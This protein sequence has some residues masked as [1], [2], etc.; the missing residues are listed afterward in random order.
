M[1]E[2]YECIF[3]REGDKLITKPDRSPIIEYA[4]LGKVCQGH[5]EKYWR[6]FVWK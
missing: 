6:R 5:R 4:G 2:E 3:C 1:T